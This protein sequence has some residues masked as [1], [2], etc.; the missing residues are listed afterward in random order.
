MST[1]DRGFGGADG[2][3]LT[4]PEDIIEYYQDRPVEFYRDMGFDLADTQIEILEACRDHHRVHVWSGNGTGKTAGVM[5]AQYHYV[6]TQWNAIGLTT[7]GSYDVMRD[8]SWPFLQTIH[9]RAKA[10]F[11]IHAEAKQSPPR[12]EFPPEKFP[13]WWIKFRSP[14]NPK[15]LE[16][17]HGRAAFVVVD[18]IDK[19]DVTAEHLDAATSTASSKSDVCVTICNPPDDRGDVAYQL[20][21][22]D[23]WHTIEFDSFDAHNAKRQLGELP[24]G[25]DRGYIPGL[26]ELDL[27]IEDYEAWNGR[28]WPGVDEVRQAVTIEDGKRVARGDWRSLDPRWYQKRLGVM[29]P[30]GSGT[31]RP[32]YERHVDA[33]IDRWNDV[34]ADGELP[35]RARGNYVAQMGA[36]MARDG[37]DRTVVVLRWDNGFLE[38]LKEVRVRDLVHAKEVLLEADDQVQR[39]PT[40]LFLIDAIGE[41]SGPADEVRQERDRVRRFKASENESRDDDPTEDVRYRNRG[42]EAAVDL[43]N[44]LKNG[45]LMVRPNSTLEK[46]LREAARVYRLKKKTWKGQEV[47]E[48]KGKEDLKTGS[49]LGRSPD[50][51]DAAMLSAYDGFEGDAD[52]SAFDLGGV[53][54]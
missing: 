11:P 2:S 15:N 7:S 49:R 48:L 41:G 13:E 6:M 54:G 24:E 21:D 16:G 9:Q 26:V 43:G 33:A 32:W 42:T 30:S 50:V 20:W 12:I 28:D 39:T 35:S 17:R 40:G 31:L 23:R 53:V 18:E 5:M 38:V 25:D 37:G 46:E 52:P 22:S 3:G 8:T 29:P 36:D 19:P 44:A 10:N 45:E 1:P 34:T 47:Y 14:K 51:A 4:S 27:I